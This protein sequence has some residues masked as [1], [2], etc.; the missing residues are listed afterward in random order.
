MNILKRKTSL[1]TS[2]FACI[3]MLTLAHN[4]PAQEMPSDYQQVL[5][6]VGKSGDYKLNVLKV[7]IPRND[8]RMRI[9]GEPV[10]TPFGFGGW[11][12]M[13]KSDGGEDVVMGRSSAYSRR[14]ESGDVR[15]SRSRYRGNGLA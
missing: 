6:T 4:V 3:A 12:A 8:L 14:S 2:A 10:P 1:A 13:A 11:F 9:S 15:P 5:K 7:N